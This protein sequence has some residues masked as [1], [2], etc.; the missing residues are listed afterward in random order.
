MNIGGPEE[1]GQSIDDQRAKIA[2]FAKM[3]GI[4]PLQ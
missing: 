4:K 1:F 3:L 2:A